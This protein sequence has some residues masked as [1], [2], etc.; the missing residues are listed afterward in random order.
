MSYGKV[1]AGVLLSGA[2]AVALHAADNIVP[3]RAF[4]DAVQRAY[5]VPTIESIG[6]PLL[7]AHRIVRFASTVT[8]APRPKVCAIPLLPV[9]GLKTQDRMAKP[10]IEPKIDPKMARPLGIPACPWDMRR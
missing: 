10:G 9:P 4:S 1:L 3:K 7:K 6:G 2:A 8:L 5:G